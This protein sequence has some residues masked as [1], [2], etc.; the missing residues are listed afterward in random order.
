[1]LRIL[2]IVQA[3][4]FG[5][6]QRIA[7]QLAGQQRLAG[8][9]ARILTPDRHQ[10]L[11]AQLEEG[12][13]PYLS[14]RSKSPFGLLSWKRFHRWVKLFSPDI[15]HLH[16]ALPSSLAVLA[17]GVGKK[18]PWI[19]HAHTY[20][21]EKPDWKNRLVKSL[22][23]AK[24]DAVVGVSQSVTEAT[25]E[26]LGQSIKIFHTIYNGV[27]ITEAPSLVRPGPECLG[28]IP[29][30]RPLIG[31]ATRFAPDK[32]IKEFITAI[33]TISAYLP[34]ARFILAGEGP[35]LSWARTY[36]ASLG[37]DG[38]LALP[39]FIQDMPRFWSSLDFALFTSP[40]EPFGL[41]IIEP[42]AA[43]VVVVGYRNGSGS[44]EVI[45]SGKTGVLVP[46]REE[47]K[48]AQEL[49]DLWDNQKRYGQVAAAAYDRLRTHFS[50][51]GMSQQCLELYDELL[52]K[53]QGKI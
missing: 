6:A 4:P 52:H 13:I 9:D 46:W 10:A 38:K 53:I 3:V 34:E 33:P 18:C 22:L 17:L 26:Y 11:S 44:D 49:A 5:G 23:G 43:G 31:M 30:G 35:L 8:Q 24:V 7:G 45:D 32:G 2:H 25:R 37:L 27:E 16:M 14:L 48:L 51:A 40:R 36:G 12:N 41:R 21:P 39:G 15:I 20:P 50:L 29:F 19:Y 42:Q 28:N 1:M 47:E